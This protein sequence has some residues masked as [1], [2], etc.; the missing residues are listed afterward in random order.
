MKTP[1]LLKKFSILYAFT[2]IFLVP[3]LNFAD[4]S[5][6][7]LVEIN[8]LLG[9]VNSSPCTFNRN[10]AKHLGKESINHIQRKYDYFKDDIVTSEDFIKYS[11][12]KST[13]SGKYYTVDCP[14]KTTIKS[15]DWLLDELKQFRLQKK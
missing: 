7:Q 15:K 12:T 10:G 11:A 3:G 9:F 2:L 8:H 13:M 1:H 4:T 14:G 5:K 6:E